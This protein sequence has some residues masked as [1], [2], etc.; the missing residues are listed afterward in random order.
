[1]LSTYETRQPEV[2]ACLPIVRKSQDQ[3][4]KW[5]QGLIVSYHSI[6]ISWCVIFVFFIRFDPSSKRS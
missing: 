3:S 4:V 2:V 6:M 5:R 1:L